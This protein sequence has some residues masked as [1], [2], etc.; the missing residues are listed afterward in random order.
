MAKTKAKLDKDTRWGMILAM[1]FAGILIGGAAIYYIWQPNAKAEK[2]EARQSHYLT[3]GEQRLAIG[4]NSLLLQMSVEYVGSETGEALTEAQPRL[5]DQ[6]LKVLYTSDV[7][8]LRTTQGKKALAG[9]VLKAVRDALPDEHAGS[10]KEI[11]YEK[12]LIGE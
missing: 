5:K 11:L 6:V 8:Q 4:S 3:L 9:K 7:P 2:A 12:F 1:L 10:V